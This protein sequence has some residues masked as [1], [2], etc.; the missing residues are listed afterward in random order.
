MTYLS[1]ILSVVLALLGTPLFVII[2]AGALLY[3]YGVDIDSSVVII[4]MYRISS[5]PILLAIPLFAFAGYVLAESNAPR[6]LVKFSNAFLG[7]LPGGFA[8]IALLISALL[9]AL[10]GASGITIVAVGGVLF[11]SLIKE[12][13][14]EKFSLGLLTTSGSLGLLFAPSLPLIIYGVIAQIPIKKLFIAGFLPGILMMILLALFSMTQGIAARVPRKEFSWREG[15]SALREIIWDIPLIMLVV[16]GIYSGY[17]AVSEAAAIIAFYVLMVEVIIL[18]EVKW[19]RLFH[20]MK[21]SMVLVGAILIILGASLGFT[22][23][24]IDAEI[25]MK[26]LA[27]FKAHITSKLLFLIMLNIFLLLVG[28]M[29]DIFSALVVV[30]PL[31]IPIAK[32]YGVDLI[33]LGIIFV[34]NLQIGYSTP[35]I[36]MNL[37]I[38]SLRFKQPV[39]KLYSASLP[40]LGILLVA[41]MIITYVPDLSLFL[42]KYFH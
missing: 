21:E 24:L 7:W 12:K 41:L 33:H 19:Q 22:N 34:T 4:E 11:P 28:C 9:T 30:L 26:I 18:K 13:Y 38:A 36:G 10:T 5:M 15:A 31:I 3:F 8:V 40:F 29:L 16:V 27:F 39:V 23:Y 37:F 1:G 20:V 32:G 25:P 6:R 35:P 14:P 2:A 17:I 42:L